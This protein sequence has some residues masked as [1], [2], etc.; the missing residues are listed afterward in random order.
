MLTIS[1]SGESQP[2]LELT[3]RGMRIRLQQP[4]ERKQ[5]SILLRFCFLELELL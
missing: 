5:V 4:E 3:A 1:G 2:W